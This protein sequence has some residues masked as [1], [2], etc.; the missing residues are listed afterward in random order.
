MDAWDFH[1][2]LP[3]EVHTCT[4]YMYIESL[5]LSYTIE[6]MHIQYVLLQTYM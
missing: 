2:I 4:M 3:S 6:T 5:E 1:L